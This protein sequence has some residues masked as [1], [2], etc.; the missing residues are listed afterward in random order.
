MHEIAQE[1]TVM[2]L[3]AN[4]DGQVIISVKQPAGCWIW[5]TFQLNTQ[6]YN[7]SCLQKIIFKIQNN[8]IAPESRN[9]KYR[10]YIVDGIYVS[11][12]PPKRKQT[13]KTDYVMV[14]ETPDMYEKYIK[15]QVHCPEWITRIENGSAE[16]ETILSENK[17]Y[18]LLPDFKW[19][20]KTKNLYLLVI[21]KDHRLGSIRDLTEDDVPLLER[22][23]QQV[24][25][26]VTDNYGLS[27][28]KIRCFFHYLPSA[29]R[30]HMHVQHISADTALGSGTQ[31][32]RART[33]GEVIGNIKLIPNYYQVIALDCVLARDRYNAY[34][35]KI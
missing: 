7:Y 32:A 18:Y 22:T 5:Y 20:R 24:L 15:P 2:K 4:H 17:D 10:N 29:W 11:V 19:D 31:C 12:G 23:Q 9:G 25:K 6:Q 8:N 33:V 1:T 27:S 21:F 13:A 30:L 28:D 35:G 14:R 3:V 26:F 16:G 34:Y